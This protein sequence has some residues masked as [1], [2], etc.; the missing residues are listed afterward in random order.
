M[1]MLL[2]KFEVM[3]QILEVQGSIVEVGVHFGAGCSSG[4]SLRDPGAAELSATIHGFDNFPVRRD[5]REGRSFA[6]EH[7]SAT[8]RTWRRCV[9]DLQENIRIYDSTRALGH[10]EKAFCIRA[11]LPDHTAFVDRQPSARREHALSGRRLYAPTRTA[12]ECL[13]DRIPKGG[14]IVFDELIATNSRRDGGCARADRHRNLRIRRSPFDTWM[15][16]AIKSS[17][18]CA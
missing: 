11:M 18:R 9:E 16:Y 5:H 13:Y 1:T 7:P 4:C 6:Q 12:I 17:S 10:I 8:G 15:S 14:V 3:K 2:S